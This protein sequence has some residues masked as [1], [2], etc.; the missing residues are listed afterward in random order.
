M[1]ASQYDFLPLCR[2]IKGKGTMATWVVSASEEQRAIIES[3][4][5]DYWVQTAADLQGTAREGEK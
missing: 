4:S 3:T 1:L 5:M 2:N